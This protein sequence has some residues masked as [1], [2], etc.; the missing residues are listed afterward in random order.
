MFTCPNDSTH[1][2]FETR[3]QELHTVTWIIDKTGKKVNSMPFKID[4][5]SR[6]G[7]NP[8]ICKKCGAVA[9]KAP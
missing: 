2:M 8:V 6:V 7:D 3:M 4:V 1:P 5:Q 9:E